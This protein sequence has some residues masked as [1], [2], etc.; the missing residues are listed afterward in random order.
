[1]A[2]APS[3]GT[4][5]KV[6]A[7]ISTSALPRLIVIGTA[8][9]SPAAAVT[10]PAL[11]FTAAAMSGVSSRLRVMKP[12][13]T[14]TDRACHLLTRFIPATLMS[15]ARDNPRGFARASILRRHLHGP[16]IST[17]AAA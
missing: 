14:R 12:P 7:K 8:A 15:S 17:I 2:E 1:M 13:N 9:A 5:V 10:L 6:T 3:C 4:T 11:M 16:P